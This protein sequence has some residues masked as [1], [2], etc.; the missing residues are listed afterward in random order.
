MGYSQGTS[1]KTDMKIDLFF[2]FVMV[3]AEGVSA[4][5]RPLSVK[6]RTDRF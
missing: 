2:G 3:A 5:V 4:A 1:T 6:K